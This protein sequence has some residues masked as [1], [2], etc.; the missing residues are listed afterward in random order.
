MFFSSK[1]ENY[2]NVLS[3]SKPKFFVVFCFPSFH[4]GQLD[5]DRALGN[6]KEVSQGKHHIECVLKCRIVRNICQKNTYWIIKYL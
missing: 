1:R 3:Q 2:N 4:K 6:G 5:T